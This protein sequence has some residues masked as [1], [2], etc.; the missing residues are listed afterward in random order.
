MLGVYFFAQTE[1]KGALLKG[2]LR[3]FCFVASF[4]KVL[5]LRFADYISIS[6]F[7]LSPIPLFIGGIALR[8]QKQCF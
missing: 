2:T 8:F 6:L 7:G 1:E 3:F 4:E 5:T